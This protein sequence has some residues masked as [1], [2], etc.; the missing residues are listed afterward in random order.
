[1]KATHHCPKC[2]SSDI[3]KFE[4]SQYKPASIGATNSWGLNIAIIDRY[5]CMHC[6]YTEEYAQMTKKFLK[7][8]N[9]QIKKQGGFNDGFV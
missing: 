5:F 4:G 2:N 9:E 6:G 8:G 3:A 1:M 7:W